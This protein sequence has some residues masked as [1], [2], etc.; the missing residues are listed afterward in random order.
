MTNS[1]Y[2]GKFSLLHI[3]LLR[4]YI[5]MTGS[6]KQPRRVLI[7]SAN[8]LFREGLR[9]MYA[10]RWG[11]RATIVGMPTDMTIALVELE[12]KAPDLVIV[13]FDDKTIN[14]SAFLNQF[15]T[16]KAPMQVMLVSLQESGQVLVYDRRTLTSAQAEDWLNDPWSE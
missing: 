10:D 15:V 14:R 3:E 16:G 4:E 5:H 13:D 8:P 1:Q 6:P 9:K 7:V 11:D 12:T 2:F